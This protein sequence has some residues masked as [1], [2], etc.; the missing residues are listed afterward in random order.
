M[1]KQEVTEEI[2]N[3]EGVTILDKT[4]NFDSEMIPKKEVFNIINQ[5]DEP[6]KPVVPQFVADWY[7]GHKR[8]LE[9]TLRQLGLDMMNGVFDNTE[10]KGWLNN[11]NN[12]PIQTIV[13]M[14][15][16]DYEVEKEKLY[17]VELPNSNYQGSGHFVLHKDEK[18][19]V[20]IDW[21]YSEN[22]KKLDGVE[23]TES[24][25]KEDYDWAWQFAEE[26]EE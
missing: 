12:K 15:Q 21:H 11:S 6:E 16:F 20:F 1:N 7:E 8:S 14:H 23:L 10:M 5:I 4:I 19:K 2:K 3:L 26:V 24:E 22:W 13:N 17:T 25:I 18:G 9:W